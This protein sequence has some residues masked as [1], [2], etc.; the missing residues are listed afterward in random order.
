MNTVDNKCL[1][2]GL[3]ISMRRK[4]ILISL[5]YPP[6]GSMFAKKFIEHIC[7]NKTFIFIDKSSFQGFN[8][9]LQYWQDKN[10]PRVI[11][12]YGKNHSF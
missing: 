5:A 8:N 10:N 1:L 4:P 2:K 7:Q 3:K 12:N 9:K 6:F 11:Y